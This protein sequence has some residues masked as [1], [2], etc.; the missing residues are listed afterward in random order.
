MSAAR[1]F[2]SLLIL[3]LLTQALAFGSKKPQSSKV[4]PSKLE[5][6]I[7]EILADPDAARAWWGI[8]VVSLDSGKQVYGL[9]QEKLFTPASNSKLFTTAAVFA[10]IGPSYRF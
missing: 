9:N 5:R 2:A 6:E 8:D 4:E 7:A 1:Q 3:L 10:L